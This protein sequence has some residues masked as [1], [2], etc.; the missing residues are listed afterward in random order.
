VSF[1]FGYISFLFV[2]SLFINQASFLLRY[3][4]FFDKAGSFLGE[5]ISGFPIYYSVLEE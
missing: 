4:S 2:E 5:K 3:V 1:L